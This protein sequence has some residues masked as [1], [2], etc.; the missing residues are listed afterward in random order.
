MTQLNHLVRRHY[1]V[2]RKCGAGCGEL[3]ARRFAHHYVPLA[4]LKSE[5]QG[6][7]YS[8]RGLPRAWAEVAAAGPREG[9]AAPTSLF[10]PHIVTP[11]SISQSHHRMARHPGG[12]ALDHHLGLR[13]WGHL[14][15]L[16]RR[17]PFPDAWITPLDVPPAPAAGEQAF[18]SPSASP[19]SVPR[20]TG[21]LPP[22]AMGWDGCTGTETRAPLMPW[23]YLQMTCDI[24][25]LLAQR[26]S[27]SGVWGFAQPARPPRAAPDPNV[28]SPFPLPRACSTLSSIFLCPCCSSFSFFSMTYCSVP[29]A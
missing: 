9:G 18:K 11:Q 4:A 29:A 24:L 16:L 1:L 13:G 5:S 8:L 6:I 26:E 12:A 28:P 14:H 20:S 17:V 2:Q 10:L 23:V 15:L 7:S 22:R 27:S 21:V 25:F 3:A 19:S